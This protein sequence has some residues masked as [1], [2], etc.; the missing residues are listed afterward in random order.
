MLRFAF[1][2]LLILAALLSIYFFTV[3]GT[4]WA[5]A[6]IVAVLLIAGLLG[7]FRRGGRDL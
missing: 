6:P 7:A 5:F 2:A 3:D 4:L 1:P